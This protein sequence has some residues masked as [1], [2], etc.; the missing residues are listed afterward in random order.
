MA[1]QSAG[2][3]TGG[4]TPVFSMAIDLLPLPL[5]F[6]LLGV[7]MAAI[8]S[9]FAM[10]LL[11]VATCLCYDIQKTYFTKRPWTMKE[12]RKWVR[13]WL[14]ALTVLNLV[15]A[16]VLPT[17]SNAVL[18]TV[19]WMA[20]CSI[21]FIIGML[22]KRSTFSAIF[23]IAVCWIVNVLLSVTPIMP[24]LRIDGVNYAIVMIILTLI[25]GFIMTGLDKTA[26]PAFIKVYKQQR[27]DW[28]AVRK[29][30]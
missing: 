25:I 13:F 12:D 17:V 8:L 26:K 14:V 6:L 10:M 16:T 4:G 29:L 3:G 22:Y 23:T 15:I 5:A 28:D 7:F 24:M 30:A 1:A 2:Y 20:P 19:S 18:W 9:T 21:V 11:G 27:A